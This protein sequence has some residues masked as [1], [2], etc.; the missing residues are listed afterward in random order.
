M[1]A[2]TFFFF[3]FFPFLNSKIKIHGETKRQEV[4][5]RHSSLEVW[6][7]SWFWWHQLV[8]IRVFESACTCL[9]WRPVGRQNSESQETKFKWPDSVSFTC[10]Y[11]TF[12]PFKRC[13]VRTA[14]QHLRGKKKNWK[15]IML[16]LLINK[17]LIGAVSSTRLLLHSLM[18]ILPSV[19][20]QTQRASCS[21]Y[22]T[23]M[24]HSAIQPEINSRQWLLSEFY[25]N[26]DATW[27]RK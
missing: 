17:M 21:K 7:P 19:N 27:W 2:D 4:M 11:T 5:N 18:L 3:F 6:L 14:T 25:T 9:K 22:I 26:R 12:L 1:G 10:F 13:H 16:I 24:S 15:F 20:T 23:V 8:K